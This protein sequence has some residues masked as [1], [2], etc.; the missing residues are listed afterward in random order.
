[1]LQTIKEYVVLYAPTVFMAIS[2]FVSWFKTKAQLR[3][4]VEK[5]T[6]SAEIDKLRKEIKQLREQISCENHYYVK[7]IEQNEK[8]LRGEENDETEEIESRANTDLDNVKIE[9]EPALASTEEK[10]DETAN[11][12]EVLKQ[13][14]AKKFN[15]KQ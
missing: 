13:A 15:L 5:I 6:K 2:S 4:N 14:F 1:M 10:V 12:R 7:L 8:L 11:T 3:L 9:D